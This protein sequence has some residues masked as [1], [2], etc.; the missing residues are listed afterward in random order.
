[1][2]DNWFHIRNHGGQ[3]A[4]RW[5]MQNAE[6]KRKQTKNSIPAKLPLKRERDIK[7]LSD[8]KKKKKENREYV[9][10]KPTLQKIVKGL[11]QLK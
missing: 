6:R 8:L 4:G 1:M 10:N 2:I 7:K 5:H 3:R 9:T 11:F